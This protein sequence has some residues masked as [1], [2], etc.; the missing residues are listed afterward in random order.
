MEPITLRYFRKVAE[1]GSIRN[2]A[3]RLFVAQ[4][5]VSRQVALL[6]EELGVPLFERRPRGMTLTDA[7]QLLLEYS[8]DMRSRFEELRGMIQEYETLQRGHVEIASVE[9]LLASFL[10]EAISIFS[11]DFPGISLNVV[12]FGSNAVAEAVAEH[13]SDLGIV[14]GNAPRND[15]LELA[16]MHQPLCLLVA[17]DHPLAAEN[18][19]SLEEAAAFPLVLP[20]R[21]FGIRQ[22]VDRISASGKFTLNAPFETNTLAFA[23]QLVM[24]S[25]FRAT[26]MPIDFASQE[27]KVGA[28]VALSLTDP[29]LSSTN[30]TLVASS[31]RKLSPSARH[32]AHHLGKLMML[33]VPAMQPVTCIR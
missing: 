31:M 22:L 24:K 6:E 15:L 23:R 9:G 32:L 26:F 25:N 12:A 18:Q 3:E 17:P 4:S 27:I 33:K 14:F 28:L 2:A 10:P 29:V 7:G 16:C 30:V 13:R 5:A 11:E 21:S 19:C 1:H 20:D 8:H